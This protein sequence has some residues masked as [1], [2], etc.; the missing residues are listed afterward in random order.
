MR[1]QKKCTA[2]LLSST[3]IFQSSVSLADSNN[4]TDDFELE[5]SAG[6][7]SGGA[8]N[9][10]VL[11]T[12]PSA[13]EM[14]DSSLVEEEVTTSSAVT[15]DMLESK[16]TDALEK[17]KADEEAGIVFA[18]EELNSLYLLNSDEN[19]PLSYFKAT[20]DAAKQLV[21][22]NSK[23]EEAI[24][25][26]YDAIDTA[27]NKIKILGTR[28]TYN[29]FSGTDGTVW[30]DTNGIKIQAHGG[31]V[32]WLENEGKWYWYGED[33]TKGYRSN[34]ISAYSSS[35]LYNWTFEGYVMRTVS[36]REQLDTD[37]YFSELY[38][39]YTA[40]EKD[41]V[42]LCINNSNSVI[43]RPKMIYNKKTGKYVLWFHADGPTL[44]APN[45]NYA[46]AS[47]G[48]AISDSPNGPFKFID[49]YRLDVC[50][51]E[52]KTGAWYEA[53][54]GFARDMNL[55][56]DD[57][58]TAYIIYSSEEN[59]TMFISRLNDEY[60]NLNVDPQHSVKGK[61]FVRLFP[62]AQ[63]EA[64]A[65]FKYNNKYY[66]ITSSATG[67]DPNQA[68]YWVADDILGEW[69][70]MGDP[71]IGDIDKKTFYTQSTN[72]IPV[73][74]DSGKF[75]YMGDR[76]KSDNLADSR[77]V[78]LPVE[79]DPNGKLAIKSYT[80]WTLED[81]NNK[82]SIKLNTPLK[83]VYTSVDDLP[84]TVNVS[85][86]ENGH[87]VNKDTTVTWDIPELKPTVQTTITGRLDG[88]GR[89][90]SVNVINIP[91]N[92][93]YYIDCG[94]A[95]SSIF[96]LINENAT[97]K[98]IN[99]GDQ[100]Y[101]E[102]SWGYSS[103]IGTDIDLYETSSTNSFDTGYWAHSGKT[104]DYVVP[105]ETGNYNLFAGF[106]EWWNTN[107]NMGISIS[108]KD[109][110]G[111]VVKQKLGTF[112]NKGQKTV[113][114]SFNLP[115]A[116]DVTISVY[117]L[118][119]SDPDVILSWL[120]IQFDNV[121]IPRGENPNMK[122]LY[123]GADELPQTL[124]IKAFEN[125][126]W[127][128]RNT[129][130]TWEIPTLT[131]MVQTTVT[132]TL[133]YNGKKIKADIINVPKNLQYFIDCGAV[134]GST[135]YDLI[136]KKVQLINNDKSDKAYEEG[137][138]G[139]VGKI[140]TDINYKNSDN[141]DAYNSGLWAY[142]GKNIEYAVNLKAGKYNL[143][144]GFNEWWGANRTM[145]I[146]VSYTDA[147]GQ[148]VKQELG[149][150]TNNSKK[151]VNYEF[152]LHEDAQ[153][154][155]SVYKLNASNPDVIL[156][157]L[158]VEA[159]KEEPTNPSDPTD[160][161]EPT[162]PATPSNPTDP[163][164]P[165]DP[166]TPSDPTDPAK[167]IEPTTPVDPTQPG[168]SNN[169]GSNSNGGNS[170][171][172]HSS[173]SSSS[174]SSSDKDGTVVADTSSINFNAIAE[175]ATAKVINSLNGEIG[176]GVTSNKISQITNADGN[177][178]SITTLSKNGKFVGSVI[179]AEKESTA[180]TIP[181][182]STSEKVT[183]VYKF[184]PRLGKYIQITDGF[185]IGADAITL[186]VQANS[187]YLAVIESI[188]SA[189][190]VTQGWNKVGN[191]WY[192]L[193]QTGDLKTGWQKD[194]LGW[195]YLSPDNGEMQTG[196]NKQGNTWY[197][198]NLNGYMSTGWVN[199]NGKW[200]YLN[201]SGAMATGWVKDNEVWYYLD[202]S[203][204]MVANTIIDGYQLGENGALF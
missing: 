70:D 198:L 31:Q 104:I 64:P 109:A 88:I 155:I 192:L 34:G 29:S 43:E 86:I 46:A 135:L 125:N 190:T 17:E 74:K 89:D 15:I 93:K 24:K 2:V 98:N 106:N 53:S 99:A 128:S 105:L 12:T 153:V 87:K 138:W 38:K 35:D 178:L 121:E 122:D 130:V 161:S 8:Q 1:I 56:I 13:V 191:K 133:G 147:S 127:V 50:P 115:V 149:T 141:T 47:A 202:Q 6:Q 79:F 139:Y 54:A 177:R 5:T 32:Q 62:G 26:A 30:K 51:E 100:A 201:P 19:T 167:P 136:N 4:D 20:I 60:T 168:G 162:D 144:A 131:P 152:E 150:F 160:P 196:W 103:R 65:L 49:R 166:T 11:T 58:D 69:T 84:S 116:S 165:T 76:W 110:N 124:N 117:K 9:N 140:G 52:D 44:E 126:E 203:G 156:S 27:Y 142:S 159:I 37:P 14:V 197:Y 42:Y 75:I 151:L 176:A 108:Y 63:R 194:D 102:G 188:S 23:N 134:N 66:M 183:A 101:I 45:S 193:S 195:V 68:K 182:L 57:D 158:A 114:Y 189:D 95:E 119:S 82:Y 120:A 25:S 184:V 28:E 113:D 36:S 173:N 112:T 59:R 187:T 39:D 164:K 61:D 146:R 80:D 137:S 67:W 94:N 154:T 123:T 3:L 180:A 204:A 33:H 71:C 145:G 90:I 81:L 73:D 97:L 157:W 48:V 132:G 41:N 179:V 172:G 78:W 199:S 129:T 181:V 7:V 16:I 18:T 171:S 163:S 83:D 185:L 72:V 91:K 107:R 143:F 169:G 55:W 111:Q 200:Y 174:S 96:K 21:E 186:P 148:L 22:A 40:E 175:T 170:N 77:Y 85:I 10:D 92:L 118:N